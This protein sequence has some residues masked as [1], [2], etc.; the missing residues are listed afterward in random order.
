MK[1]FYGRIGK[2]LPDAKGQVRFTFVHAS[3]AILELKM[4]S[5]KPLPLEHQRVIAMGELVGP[6]VIV[7][8]EIRPDGD[9]A[10]ESAHALND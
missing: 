10:A 1:A 7:G 5:G 2:R 6:G 3:G 9:S 4:G 8:Q